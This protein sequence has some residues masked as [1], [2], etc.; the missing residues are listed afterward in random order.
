VADK[1]LNVQARTPNLLEL[2]LED[3]GGAGRDTH[4]RPN[5]LAEYPRATAPGGKGSEKDR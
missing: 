2:A 5:A 3:N 4:P 1:A